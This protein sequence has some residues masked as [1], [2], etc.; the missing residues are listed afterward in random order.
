M[1]TISIKQ[2][3]ETTGKWVRSAKV[4][5]LVITDHGDKI[6]ILRQFSEEEHGGAPFPK[7]RPEDL[8]NV[9]VDSTRLISDDRDGR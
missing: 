2:L 1:K 7:R 9:G 5:P 8:P 6:A 3:H 4:E